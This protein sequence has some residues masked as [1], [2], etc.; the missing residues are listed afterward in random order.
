MPFEATNV[1]FSSSSLYTEAIL[2]KSHNFFSSQVEILG[3][4]SPLYESPN[5]PL[6]G[7]LQWGFSLV[8]NQNL[9]TRFLFCTYLQILIILVLSDV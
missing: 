6:P 9:V 7:M 3:A 8:S 4:R 5:L 1:L 2:K